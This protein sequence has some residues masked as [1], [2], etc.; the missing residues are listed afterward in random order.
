[1]EGQSASR[2]SEIIGQSINAIL[3]QMSDPE[4]AVWREK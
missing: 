4:G 2:M 1:L 3:T